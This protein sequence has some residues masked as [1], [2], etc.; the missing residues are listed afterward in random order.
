M[1]FR[2]EAIVS[3]FQLMELATI[4]ST[5]DFKA[6][7]H[8]LDERP[9][10]K[11]SLWGV[12]HFKDFQAFAGSGSIT[13]FIT[14]PDSSTKYFET[15]AIQIGAVLENREA[16]VLF[17]NDVTRYH[18]DRQ[19]RKRGKRRG[20]KVCSFSL[21]SARSLSPN[22]PSS[23]TCQCSP[24]SKACLVHIEVQVLSFPFQWCSIQFWDEF[25]CRKYYE[26][27]CLGKQSWNEEIFNFLSCHFYA[28]FRT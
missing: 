28:L 9:Q 20:D 5:T 19:R 14:F 18:I 23:L 8:S 1:F 15:P 25:S 13:C 10:K 17:A 22:P 26:S 2:C 11:G 6:S 27:K 7:W 3:L 12:A 16:S 21:S 4:Q 24:S